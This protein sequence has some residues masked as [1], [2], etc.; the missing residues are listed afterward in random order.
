MNKYIYIHT[1]IYIHIYIRQNYQGLG[2]CRGK[3]PLTSQKFAHSPSKF[4]TTKFSFQ[5]M[6]ERK[7]PVIQ[8]YKLLLSDV[9]LKILLN[10]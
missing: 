9:K 4:P 8:H 5:M 2:K 3:Y 10:S 6:D 1:Y 7:N